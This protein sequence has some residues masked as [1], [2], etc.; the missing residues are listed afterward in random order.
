MADW[1]GFLSYVHED[2]D[3]ERGRI[4][5]VAGDLEAQFKLLTGESI[6]IFLDKD[7][8]KW[9]DVWLDK[10][11]QGLASVACFIPVLTPSYFQSHHCRREL[12]G[13]A[14]HATKLGYKQLVMPLYWATVKELDDKEATDDLKVLVSTFQRADWRDLRL[15]N[16]DSEAYRR[17]IADL[18]AR[19]VTANAEAEKVDLAS[20]ELAVEATR[21]EPAEELGVLE[22]IAATE[23]TMPEMTATIESMANTVEAIGALMT[24]STEDVARADAQ[25]KGFAGRLATAHH[26]AIQL[27]EPAAEVE[28]LGNRFAS[29]LHVVDAGMR[30]MIESL[31]EQ[32]ALDSDS[33]TAACE[34]FAVLRNFVRSTRES[35]AGTQSMLDTLTPLE[36]LSRELRVPLRLIR[37]GLT[38]MLEAGE[39]SD[40]WI[41]LID[42]GALDCPDA[43][44]DHADA[45]SLP[46]PEDEKGPSPAI[47]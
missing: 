24:Q 41:R 4:S 25:N 38:S 37:Q 32:G 16:V 46:Q 45:D 18:A 27:A 1:Q 39:V 7:A 43:T 9:G 17:G 47:H 35:M 20:A 36:K 22:L 33:R 3:A 8:I 11:D 21:E 31:N 6:H 40:E 14:D 2:D 19:L 34:Y 5:R 44:G 12:R 15:T 30:V 13:F 26:L 10:I 28:S 23:Q 42:A 29:Q